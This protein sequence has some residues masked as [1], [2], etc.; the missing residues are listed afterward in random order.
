MFMNSILQ[1]A[2]GSKMCL[3]DLLIGQKGI[4]I[5]IDE[6]CNN[7]LRLTELGFTPDAKIIP[8]HK[9]LSGGITAYWVKG[10]VMALRSSDA[11]YIKI[12]T[13]EDIL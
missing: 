10:A 13:E 2:G 6:K 5:Y 9:S 8:V 3:S 4:I 11:K 1:K 12:C 7:K